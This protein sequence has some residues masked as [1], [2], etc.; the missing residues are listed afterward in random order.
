MMR[1]A[2][3]MLFRD[4]AKFFGIVMGVTLASLVITQQGAI[5]TGLM[6]RT[7]AAISDM[8]DP[9]IWVMDPKVQFIDD[10]KPLQDTSLYRVRGVEGV[11]FAAPLYKGLIRARLDNGEFQNCIVI[12]LDDATLTGGPP[13]M[14]HGR[15]EDLRRADAVIVDGIGA[16]EKL[17]KPSLDPGAKPT[18]LGVGDTM[19]LNDRRGI[20]VGISANTRTFQSQPI[21]YTTYSRAKAYAPRE[22]KL[23][24]FILVKAAAGQSPADVAKRIQKATG[25]AAYTRDEFKANTVLYFLKNTGIPINFGIAV[26]LGFVIGTVITGFMFF[27]FTLDNLRYFGTLKAMGASDTRLLLMI[28]LQALMVGVIGFG[29]GVG[30]AAFFG[31]MAPKHTPLAF[32]LPW[33]LLFFSGA[34]V[35]IICTLSAMLS[36]G[37]VVRLEPAMVFKG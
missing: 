17:S 10:I 31:N 29:V 37:K 36:M 3:A 18:P 9:D 25:L 26:S 28:V 22:R 15:L 14:L 24:S 21:I 32:M 35:L 5:F 8:G 33:Q 4:K 13:S 16:R 23:L 7:F 11:A 12:G 2:L 19:E 1:L 27:S 30:L 20:V 6:A 34:A